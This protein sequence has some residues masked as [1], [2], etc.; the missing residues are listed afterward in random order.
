M[1][2][3]HLAATPSCMYVG[4]TRLHLDTITGPTPQQYDDMLH[5]MSKLQHLHI[6]KVSMI[7][8]PLPG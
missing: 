5:T 8:Y 6:H 1:F 3:V 7:Y 2:A 4:L